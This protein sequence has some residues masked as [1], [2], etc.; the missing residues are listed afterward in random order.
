M[1]V[2]PFPAL[3]TLVPNFGNCNFP[4]WKLRFPTL[5]ITVSCL[6]TGV[7]DVGNGALNM[8]MNLLS[9]ETGLFIYTVL[10]ILLSASYLQQVSATL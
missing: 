4:P 7:S 2:F 5:E 6:G 9:G 1:D 3:E 10:Q 8:G